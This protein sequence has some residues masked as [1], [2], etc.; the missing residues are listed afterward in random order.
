[1]EISDIYSIL[2]QPVNKGFADFIQSKL[3]EMGIT[4]NYL[5]KAINIDNKT[6]ARILNGEAKKVDVVKVLKLGDFMGITYQEFVQHYVAELKRDEIRKIESA[7]KAGFI[8]RNFDLPKL[9]AMGFIKN[10]TNFDLIEKRILNFF[11]FDSLLEYEQGFL[12]LKN[13]FSRTQKSPSEKIL[14]FWCTTAIKEFKTIDNPYPFDQTQTKSIIT[15]LS[16]ST[17]DEVNG[18]FNIVRRLYRAGVTVLINPYVGNTQV[19]GAT[20]IVNNKPC[21]ILQDF[22]KTYDTI[23]FALAHELCHVIKDLNTIDSTK[24]H[25][26]FD[27]A[28]NDLFI[29]EIIERRADNFASEILLPDNKMRYIAGHIDVP[30]VVKEFSKKWQVSESIIYGQYAYRYN[31]PTYF[32]RTQKAEVAI[33]QLM[34]RNLYEEEKIEVAIEKIKAIYI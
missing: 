32:A 17:S 23:W 10:R 26:T 24:F 4:R 15:M 27:K 30:G 3:D 2:A 16:I 5:C 11:G 29:D 25:I 7:R 34:V 12:V 18:L 20:F 6:L 21:I 28:Q 31:Q 13:L 22:R 33:K 9:K 8:L 1:M 19:R 14:K